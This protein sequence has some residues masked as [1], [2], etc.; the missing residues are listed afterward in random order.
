MTAGAEGLGPLTGTV[1]SGPSRAPLDFGPSL[2]NVP[3]V[4]GGGGWE[5]GGG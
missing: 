5:F 2:G 1:V 4:P 3:D